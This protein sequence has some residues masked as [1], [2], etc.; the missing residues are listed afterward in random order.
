MQHR[1]SDEKA[2]KGIIVL[3]ENHDLALELMKGAY[4]LH[5]HSA[6]SH[7]PRVIDD[8]GLVREADKYGMAGVMIKNHYE[9]TGARAHLVN[10]Q[11]G[12]VAKAYGSVTLNWPVGGLNP[13]AVVSAV[14][15]GARYVWMPTRDSAHCLSFGE[16]EGDFY[17]RSGISLFDSRGKIL[18][19]VYEIFEMAKVEGVYV[20]SGHLSP[21][22]IVAFCKAGRQVGAP[23]VLTHPDWERT[24]VPLEIQLEL[25]DLG[26]LVEKPYNN[27]T[28]GF[29]SSKEMARSLRKLGAERVYMTTDL[30]IA[31]LDNPAAGML[32]YIEL[33]LDEGISQQEIRTMTAEAPKRII[34]E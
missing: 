31:P 3:K 4:D 16:M 34:G 29:I 33:M 15:M 10:S 18:G 23:V 8:F 25:A 30:G 9:P 2:A 7:F 1:I 26:V 12:A 28:W 5:I 11:S 6:P 21:E 22:E 24:G 32:K 20:G 27:I 19:S 17:R 14:K 13:F